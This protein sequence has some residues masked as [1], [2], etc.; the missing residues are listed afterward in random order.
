MT[1][2][3]AR[4]YGGVAGK[5]CGESSLKY[6]GDGAEFEAFAVSASAYSAFSLM[7][8]DGFRIPL[9]LHPTACV[10]AAPAGGV[11]MV[12]AYVSAAVTAALGLAWASL[13][14]AQTPPA[15]QL[16]RE[17]FAVVDANADR[18]GRLNDAIFSYSEIG[19]QEVKT[20]ALVKKTLEGAG[21]KVTTGVAGMPTAYMATYGSGSPV[22]GLMSDFDGLPGTSQRPASLSHDPIVP[23]GPGHGEGHN[24]HQPTLMGSAMA[25]KAIKDKY[26]LPGTIIVYGGPAEELLASRGYMVN[27]GLFKGVDA[28]IDVHIG[29]GLGTSYGLNNLAIIS[30]QWSFKGRPAHGAAA[31]QGRS[32]LDA[33]ELMD[34]SMNF[35]R[36]HVDPPARIHY[37]IPNGGKQP[38]V[39]PDDAAVW[40][41]FRHTTAA[42]VWGL[43][44][45][46]RN[47]A[48]GAALQTDTKV[49]ERIMSASWSFNG[50]KALA[51]LVDGNVK[52]VGMPNWSADDQAF[53][54]AYQT[55]MGAKVTGMATEVAPLRASRQGSSSSDAG[56]VTWQAP[57]IRLTI[58]A[59]PEGELAGHHW[60]AGI[61]PATPIAHKGIAAATKVVAASFIDMMTDPAKLTVI[62]ADFE[63]Q[64]AAYPKWKSLIPPDAEPP[65]FLNTEEMGKYRPALARYEYDPDSKQTYLQ[66]LK[67]AYPPAMPASAIGKKA[68][69]AEG[70]DVES[71]GNAGDK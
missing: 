50:N 60:S 26:K 2:V 12:R 1:I 41:Y 61:A 11:R 18:M 42:N 40:Y 34:M 14:Q 68:N 21:F 38:N 58:P 28:I 46:A 55:S 30:A 52:L 13:A 22:L 37:V 19:F 4:R 17:A 53:A 69:D 10:G 43:F 45:R 70:G 5:R 3:D 63:K 35:M 16:K 36:E 54:R 47:A 24:T 44:E 65:I 9:R 6:W 8:G 15:D 32:A 51:E 66:F 62:K 39:V 57:Y 20:I 59:K 29:S 25:I 31:W 49:V 56:D 27:A 7:S 23:G 64:L 48:R 71:S 67:V 33:V